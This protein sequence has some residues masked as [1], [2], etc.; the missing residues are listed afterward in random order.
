MSTGRRTARYARSPEGYPFVVFEYAGREV[1]HGFDHTKQALFDR[2]LVYLGGD[3][4]RVV[5]PID[6]T[7]D[8]TTTRL[9]G[10]VRDPEVHAIVDAF[11]RAVERGGVR[12]GPV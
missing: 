3:F 4:E 12:P 6:V 10:F 1:A 8:G 2:G 7:I 5:P 9:R 11:F